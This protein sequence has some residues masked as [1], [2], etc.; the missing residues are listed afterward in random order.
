MRSP[1]PDPIRWLTVCL[2]CGSE[3]VRIGRASRRRRRREV[4]IGTMGMPGRI[5]ASRAAYVDA[6]VRKR[7]QTA[8]TERRQRRQARPLTT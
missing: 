1:T 3:D 7:G 8:K 6:Q 4:K 2:L 5:R